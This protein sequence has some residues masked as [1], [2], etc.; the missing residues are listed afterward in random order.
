[1]KND[2]ASILLSKIHYLNNIIPEEYKTLDFIVIA[3]GTCK[4]KNTTQNMEFYNG[5]IYNNYIINNIFNISILNNTNNNTNNITNITNISN[6]NITNTN[7]NNVSSFILMLPIHNVYEIFM[8]TYNNTIY[9]STKYYIDNKN[10]ET[11]D[12]ISINELQF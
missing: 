4:I 6:S 5:L 12:T 7:T 9:E 11:W 1:M 10:Y 8:D 3:I 2:I